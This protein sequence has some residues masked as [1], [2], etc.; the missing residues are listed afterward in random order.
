MPRLAP[1]ITL[2]GPEGAGKSVQARLLSE[3][4]QTLGWDVCLTREPGGTAVGERVRDILLHAADLD[5]LPETEALLLSAA[6]AQHV[7]DVILPALE[8]GRAVVCDRYADST[9]AYQGGGGGLP[10]DELRGVQAFATGGTQPDLRLLLDLPVAEG[11]ARRHADAGSVNRIDLAPLAY[12]ERVRS[13]FLNLA[14]AEPDGW[15]II[16]ARASVAS[17][18]EKV[19]TVVAQKVLVNYRLPAKPS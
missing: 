8:A 1:F 2:E 9:L 12:H 17:I 3:W 10:L 11:L 15:E 4:L 18:A 6:R 13:T 14:A 7:H 16:D 19:H 5:L